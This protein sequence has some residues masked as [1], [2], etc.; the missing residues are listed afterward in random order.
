MSTKPVQSKHGLS[1]AKLID[2]IVPCS[3]TFCFCRLHTSVFL[4]QSLLS[5]RSPP[6][7]NLLVL[8]ILGYLSCIIDRLLSGN[9]VLIESY[10]T[11]R[12]NS[13]KVWWSNSFLMKCTSDIYSPEI[14]SFIIK[15]PNTS[16]ECPSFPFFLHSGQYR[17][18]LSSV[19]N[20]TATVAHKVK[21]LSVIFNQSIKHTVYFRWINTGFFFWPN[22]LFIC[23]WCGWVDL[24]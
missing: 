24:I 12:I 23:Y 2:G 4:W 18:I 19:R 9:K 7:N 22:K 6:L 17:R 14:V 10:W 16:H 5:K 21:I 11:S 20:N 8:L 1:I 3:C 13:Q 15:I